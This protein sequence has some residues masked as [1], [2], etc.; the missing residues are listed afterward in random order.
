MNWHIIR[1]RNITLHLF[2]KADEEFSE[3]LRKE[4]ERIITNYNQKVNHATMEDK[5]V[6]LVDATGRPVKDRSKPVWMDYNHYQLEKEWVSHKERQILIY[7]NPA[8]WSEDEKT[9][10]IKAMQQQ[11]K[12]FK[13][14]HMNHGNRSID[15]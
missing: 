3:A 15:M 10:N 6:L 9:A 8:F 13:A 1:S 2:G 4:G 12:E 11:D 5:K 14:K 7:G